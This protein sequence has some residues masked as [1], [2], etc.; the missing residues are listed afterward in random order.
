LDG[1]QPGSTANHIGARPLAILEPLLKH[2][3][4]RTVRRAPI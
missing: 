3:L 4:I 1:C 2:C